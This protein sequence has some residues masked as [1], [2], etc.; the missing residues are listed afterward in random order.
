MNELLEIFDDAHQRVGLVAR[1]VVHKLGMWH[2][3]AN[4]F[5]FRSDGRLVVQR[6]HKNKDVWPDA[7]D[8]SVAEH[9]RPGE[10]YLAGAERGLLEELGVE[11]VH[12]EPIT[13]VIR[14]SLVIVELGINDCELQLCYKGVSDA[15]L[16]PNPDEV[17]DIRLF[18]PAELKSEMEASPADFTPWFRDRAT[19]IRLFD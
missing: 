1:N 12:L 5:L 4:I 6:R 19:E 14:S 7:W 15:T 17:A 2:R 16:F 3:T 10:E 8:L 13:G 18:S 11:N 9:L